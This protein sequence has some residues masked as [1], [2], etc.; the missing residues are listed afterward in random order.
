MQIWFSV[1]L[2]CLFH[3]LKSHRMDGAVILSNFL[4][5]KQFRG[6]PMSLRTPLQE[7][8]FPWVSSDCQLYPAAHLRLRR[9]A[10]P[11]QP[12]QWGFSTSCI[13]SATAGWRKW[14]RLRI[15][16][17]EHDQTN[18]DVIMHILILW[19][20]PVQWYVAVLFKPLFPS[21]LIGGNK[22][23]AEIKGHC[24]KPWLKALAKSFELGEMLL[25]YRHP[26]NSFSP[27]S[28]GIQVVC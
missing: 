24:K 12:L 8:C 11:P 9:S 15:C 2:S 16:R 7:V 1:L 20:F 27:L 14:R 19:F 25:K 18:A 13:S 17:V 28:G 5:I 23:W 6:K 10:W 4:G 22:R 21:D 26:V 3:S